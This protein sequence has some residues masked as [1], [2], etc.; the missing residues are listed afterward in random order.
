[1]EILGGRDLATYDEPG[2]LRNDPHGMAVTLAVETL[3]LLATA[4]A[5]HADYRENWRPAA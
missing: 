3:R 1:L 5:D 2:A 4:Y